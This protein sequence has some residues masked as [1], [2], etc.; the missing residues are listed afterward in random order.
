MLNRLYSWY[1]KKVV[2]SV[3]MTIVGLSIIGIYLY[4]SKTVIPE[5]TVTAKAEVKT[6]KVRDIGATNSFSSVGTVQA[7]SEARL[8]TEAGGRVTSVNTEIGKSVRAGAVLAT[9]ENAS[10]SAAVLQAQG[11]YEAALAGARSSGVGISGAQ[12]ALTSAQV[13]GMNTYQDAYIAIDGLLHTSLDE[14]FSMSGNTATGFRLDGGGQA[15]QLNSERTALETIFDGWLKDK[16]LVSNATI[17]TTLERAYADTL[18]LSQF[19]EKITVIAQKEDISTVFKQ[20]AKDAKVARLFAMRVS[21]NAT[22]KQIEGAKNAISNA[23]KGLEQAQIAGSSNTPSVAGAQIKIALGS[24]RAAQANY[25]KTLVRT[26]IFGVVNALYLKTGEYVSPSTQAAI[27]AN[28]NGL[29]ILTSVGEDDREKILIGAGVTIDGTTNGVV[30]AIAGAVDPT[31]GKVAVKVSVDE[32]NQLKN[33]STVT[34]AFTQ[35]EKS[36]F[37]EITIP[38]SA[39]KMTGAGPVAFLVTQENILKSL[40]LELG[41]ISGDSVVVKTGLT[42]DTVIVVDARGLKEGQEVVVKQ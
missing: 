7:V 25:E 11:A 34:V 23:Q 10:E 40:T 1:G 21:V 17:G 32:D 24:L 6:Q 35:E 41:A 26:P 42:P 22:L 8:Q 20:D 38:L 3:L 4:A 27:V 12:T 16:S 31:T 37:T 30:T 19:I 18:R 33:G 15:Q 14:F 36:E 29:E 5:E 13:S 2:L 9:I 39:L 28:N